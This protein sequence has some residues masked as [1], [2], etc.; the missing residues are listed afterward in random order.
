VVQVF[1]FKNKSLKKLLPWNL[2]ETSFASQHGPQ[3]L[4]SKCLKTTIVQCYK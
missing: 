1:G 4:Q 3:K 2:Q